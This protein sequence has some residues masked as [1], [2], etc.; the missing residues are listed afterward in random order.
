[1]QILACRYKMLCR[2][3]KVQIPSKKHF[4]DVAGYTAPTRQHELDHTDHT[5]HTDQEYICPDRSIDHFVGI[6]DLLGVWNC[7]K[8]MEAQGE[9]FIEGNQTAV[10]SC[11]PDGAARSIMPGRKKATYVRHEL[12]LNNS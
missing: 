12:K 10:L 1:M 11:K 3:C 4:L 9:K 7:V 6:D 2:I 8:P 5:D